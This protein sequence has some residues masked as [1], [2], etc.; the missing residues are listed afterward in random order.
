MLKKENPIRL[1]NRIKMYRLLS[2]VAAWVIFSTDVLTAQSLRRHIPLN[3]GWKSIAFDSEVKDTSFVFPLFN[4]QDWETVSVP[5]NWDQY[6]GVIRKKHGNRHGYAIYR[7]YFQYPNLRSG[8]KAFLF[9]EGV[10][11]YATVWVN[12]KKIGAHAGGRTTFTLDATDALIPGKPNLVVVY[13]EHP[14]GITDLPWVCGGCSSEIGF[15][16]GSQ[17]F[18]IFRPVSMIVTGDLRIDPFGIHVWNDETAN[19]E[20]AILHVSVSLKNYSSSSRKIRVLTQVFSTKGEKAGEAITSVNINR[21]ASE[22][23]DQQIKILKPHLWSPETPD[24][25]KVETT[26]CENGKMIDQDRANFGVRTVQWPDPKNGG[27]LLINGKPVFLNGTCEYEHALGNSHA[28]TEEEITARVHQIKAC[29]YN[30]FRDA[31]QPHNLRYQDYWEKEGILW[32]TQFSAHIWFDNESFRKNFLKLIEEWVIER[33]NNP[34]VILWGL[35]NE[36]TVPADF[37]AKCTELIRRLDPTASKQRLVTTCNGGDGTDWDVPQNWTGTY[38]G[39]PNTYNQDLKRQVLVGEY[40]AWRSVGLHAE[41]NGGGHTEEKM[42]S[43]LETKIRRAEEV[44]DSVAGHF[45]WLF[46]SHE[47]PG[48]SQ[49]GEGFRELDRIGPVNYKGLYTLWG[50]PTDVFYLY[51]SYYADPVTDPMVYIV[52]HTWPDRWTQPGR[53]SGIRVYS[54][55]DEVELFNDFGKTSLG[56][57]SKSPDGYR[58]DDLEIQTNILYAIGYVGGKAVV[59]DRIVLH[60]LPEAPGLK[61]WLIRN[62]GDR[63]LPQSGKQYLYRVNC[64]G[65]E[66]LDGF[67]N[68][69]S[70]DVHK[71]EGRVWGSKSWTDDFPGTAPFF[72]SQ[73]TTGVPV[74]GTASWELFSSFRY[75]RGKLEYLFPVEDGEYEVELYFSEPWYGAG[76]RSSAAGY[77]IFDVAINENLVLKDFDIWKEG[78]YGKVVRKIFRVQSKGGWI[79]IHFPK[80]K[81]GQA[82][83]SAIAISGMATTTPAAPSPQLLRSEEITVASWLNTG[84]H[85]FSEGGPR[86]SRLNPE[87][88]GADWLKFSSASRNVL[89]GA[90]CLVTGDAVL[91]VGMP[92]GIPLPDQIKG[93]TRMQEGVA[94]SQNGERPFDL[95]RSEV[96]AGYRLDLS[97]FQSVPFVAAAPRVKIDPAFDLKPTIGY[98]IEN[99]LIEGT[100]AVRDSINGKRCVRFIE[101]A[102]AAVSWTISVGV[103]DVYAIRLRYVNKTENAFRGRLVLYAADGTKMKEEK[104]DFM[105]YRPDK[106][107][108]LHTDT[109]TSIN[110]GSYRLVLLAE[111]A[112]GLAV[113]GL[114]IQ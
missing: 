91:Y 58:W 15:S 62:G 18:G 47:N 77:R 2:F 27:Q 73:R 82:I 110:A 103:A 53:Y 112:E 38:G 111:D 44:R 100:G 69:W 68:I 35:Q 24:L 109:G 89:A 28:F 22:K 31:H 34:A 74:E 30:G 79:R 71:K 25:Y 114:E 76:T 37:A 4:D 26:I 29:G 85:C 12:G 72:A 60:H 11:S 39:D 95:Y 90:T 54:N 64:G 56:R 5:H 6:E 8:Q 1:K 86:F 107:G 105:P 9:F 106:W 97:V 61:Q 17:P 13:A 55:C 108:L 83:I 43:I 101:P 59:E 52:S 104:V 93:F 78:G 87:L 51:R 92:S 102:G 63:L 14:S 10:G 113:A 49:S 67:G 46:Y 84:V 16:E 88:F 48:R 23:I 99:T 45:H 21:L 33:R 65:P 19:R 98:K 3:D 32:W 20:E 42:I 40:G 66:Y 81:S 41:K 57:K 36:S 94:L 96:A 7:K 50:E 75:G 80:I 70:A